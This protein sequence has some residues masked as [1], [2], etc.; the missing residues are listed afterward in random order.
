VYW[1]KKDGR[2]PEDP[3]QHNKRPLGDVPERKYM[4]N[5]KNLLL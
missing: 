2:H 4:Y 5:I 1:G 3:N